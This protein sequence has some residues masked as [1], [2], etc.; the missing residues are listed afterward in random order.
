VLGV[1]PAPCEVT[2]FPDGE[3]HVSIGESVRGGDV[4]LVQSS[5]P[6]VDT[7]LMQL[8]LL[9]DACRRAGAA[10]LTAVMPY[11]GYSRQDRR[12]SGRE[13]IGARLVA[14]LLAAAGL[15]R[16]VAVDLH[17]SALEGIFS[18]PLE[19]VTAVPL[20]AEAAG[21]ALLANA[22]IVSPDL[23]ATKLA[24]RYARILNRPVAFVHKQRLSGSS[25]A[26]RGITGEV[27]GLAP[28]IVD[29][30]ISTGGTIEGAVQALLAA[31]ATSEVV[32]IATH[33]LLVGDALGRLAALPLREVIVSDSVASNS[34]SP[35]R[36]HRVSIAPLLADVI[37][38][39]HEDR[40]LSD[41]IVHA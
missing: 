1:E 33:G 12:A 18:L 7:H 37:R 4:Y 32:V 11:F 21:A 6:P 40:S 26:V 17:S 28:L 13:P 31:G 25:V 24:A 3:L 20:L 34:S 30:M 38:R 22:V 41:L 9:A 39:L 35:L 14:D 19:H 8:L 10:R 15:T 23:G 16:V 2:K 27:R 29:D 5:S 36:L